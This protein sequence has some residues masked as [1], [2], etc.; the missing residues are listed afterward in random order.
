MLD[1]YNKDVTILGCN[2]WCDNNNYAKKVLIYLITYPIKN[3]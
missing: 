3:T 2:S 1:K